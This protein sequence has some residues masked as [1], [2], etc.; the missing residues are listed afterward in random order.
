MASIRELNGKWKAEVCVLGHRRS[1]Y[2]PTR[3]AAERW[4]SRTD[5]SIRLRD[6]E[7]R[8]VMTSVLPKRYLD[9][10]KIAEYGSDEIID[11]AI[12]AHASIGVYFLIRQGV[13]VYVGQTTDL[14][15]RLARHRRLG[16]EFDSYNFIPVDRGRL[17]E[18]ES[19]YIA[20]LMPQMNSKF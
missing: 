2:H 3:E 14:L 17:D 1:K 20:A 11:G 18:V 5:R 15:G 16:R 10:L 8:E 13:I 7:G 12:P 4:A 9:A 19:A 6:A